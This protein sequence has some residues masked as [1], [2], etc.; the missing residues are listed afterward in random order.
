[1]ESQLQQLRRLKAFF[2]DRPAAPG[3]GAGASGT[4]ADPK[5]REHRTRT[6][7]CIRVAQAVLKK[8]AEG[9]EEAAWQD[10]RDGFGYAPDP[11][12]VVLCV[13]DAWDPSMGSEDKLIVVH[14]DPRDSEP[15]RLHR[16]RILRELRTCPDLLARG[17]EARKARR[18]QKARHGSQD[19]GEHRGR[20]P[21]A[22]DRWARADRRAG[23]VPRPV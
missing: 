20:R 4:A 7:R 8:L 9:A 23:R 16:M 15:G 18:E 21:E 19:P 14:P 13:K 6:D 5:V 11:E 10:W 22:A 1:M 17:L 12:G 3:A 2:A